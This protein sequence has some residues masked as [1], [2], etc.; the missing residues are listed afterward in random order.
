MPS[1]VAIT[2]TYLV[3]RLALRRALVREQIASK[4]EK[5]RLSR[6]GR[7]TA[8]GI[9]TIAVTHDLKLNAAKFEENV[10]V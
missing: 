10:S 6:G 5:P 7:L 2:V 1:V 9:G 8:Y 3:L 4:V